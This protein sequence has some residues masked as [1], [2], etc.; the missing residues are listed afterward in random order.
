[1]KR[2][3]T[4]A[5]LCLS[6]VAALLL[7]AAA[8]LLGSERGNQWLLAQIPG[9]HI[10]AGQGRLLDAWQAQRIL[11][12]GA[13]L[14]IEL[15][16]PKLNWS[17]SCLFKGA[18]CIEQLSAQDVH[19]ETGTT[20]AEHETEPV[21]LPEL[22]LPLSLKLKQLSLGRL[23]LQGQELLRN[24][25][26]SAHSTGNQ[27]MVDT[28]T[29]EQDDLRLA[30][31]G[32][33]SLTKGWPVNLNARAQLNY[34]A[35]QTWQVQLHAQGEL[36]HR[37]NLHLSSAGFLNAQA[38]G[39]LA[40][41]NPNLAAELTL[42]SERFAPQAGLPDEQ[43]LRNIAITLSGDLAQGYA[44]QAQAELGKLAQPLPLM[45]SG[46]LFSSGVQGLKLAL[47]RAPQQQLS[48]SGTLD[49]RESFAAQAQLDWQ[50][51][52]W[53]ELLVE[54]PALDWKLKQAHGP[55]SYQDG[56][57]QGQL[58][59]QLAG[60]AGDFELSSPLEGDAHTL[61]IKDLEIKA[62]AGRIQGQIE[63][64]F[65]AQAGWKAELNLSQF[66]PA[67]WLKELPGQVQGR[68]SS[69]GQWSPQL[70]GQLSAQLNGRL[71]QQPLKLQLEAQAAPEQWQ[72]RGVQLAW[73]NNQLEGQFGLQQQKLQGRLKAQFKQLAQL[74]PGLSGQISGT[75]QLAGRLEAPQAQWQL[76]A[77]GLRLQQLASA[78]IQLSG[79]LKGQQL[80]AQLSATQLA[81]G[82][83]DLGALQLNVSGA[84]NQPQ[85]VVDWQAPDWDT[86]LT[87]SGREQA[88]RWQGALSQA[89][90]RTG[91]VN[92]QLLKPAPWNYAENA[93]LT[94]AAHCWQAGQAQLC[95]QRQ[96]L[97]PDTQLAL[98]L[99]DV[100]LNSLKP[101]LPE[102]LSWQATAQGQLSL[103]LST[104]GPRGQ[105]TL[106]A[107]PGSWQVQQDEQ[108]IEL[109][110]QTLELSGQLTPS[111]ARAQFNLGGPQ[112][113][114]LRLEAQTDPRKASKPLS[115]SFQVQGVDI[116]LAR[117]F[118]SALD[119]LKGRLDGQGQLSG[120]LLA[121]HIQGQLALSEG[122]AAGSGLPLDIEQL[123][124]KAQFSG[125]QLTV[126]GR[127]H[128]GEQGRGE[129]SG[130][131]DWRAGL[132]A[133]T[134][135]AS[136]S[137]PITLDPYGE[138]SVSTQ[139]ALQLAEQ[140]LRLSGEVQ[141]P[142]GLIEIRQLPPQAVKV[143][144]D[145]VRSDQPPPA[146]SGPSLTMDVRVLVGQERLRFKGLGL[147]A[148]IRGQLHLGDDLRST[149]E[150]KLNNGRYRAY[151]QRLTVRRARLLFN[152]PISQPYLD[153]EAVR[154]AGT[155]TA[156]IRVSGPSTA[157]VSRVFATPAMSDDQALSYLLTGRPLGGGGDNQALSSAALAM[158]LSGSLPF[159]GELAEKL[160]ISDLQLGADEVSGRLSDR[161]TLSYGL[162]MLDQG[163]L[164]TLRYELTR[165]LYLEAASGIISSLDVV[166]KRDF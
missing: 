19:I 33:L 50:N 85:L 60:P 87:L 134:Q 79:Q 97:W 69:Q 109:P 140:R 24:L 90:I 12:Q 158:G 124:L 48:L 89:H 71:R 95:A 112:L 117:P 166:Y 143:S 23:H 42:H 88:G 62:G 92:W 104:A 15:Q 9:L 141:V 58:R 96:R 81:Q 32:Q 135:F 101:W 125:D 127:F 1:M 111:L 37:L 149:G 160:G 119:T 20:S 53:E 114:N 98:S 52:P 72:L 163:S 150:L 78:Q 147:T 35:Q 145:A 113:G 31:D 29:V 4:Y 86:Q 28:L 11:W 65:D 63:L 51:L 146:P 156:G 118:I 26:L 14:R 108:T 40:P 70:L 16:E 94:L 161:L 74:W 153:V 39:W 102:D 7:G 5:L 115:G 22:T 159:T 116:S 139:L 44:V 132:S 105:F 165:R 18:L 84:L 164:L 66:N 55:L 8:G 77:Q 142:R 41:L 91:A 100:P 129:L 34:L 157:P 6:V 73:G 27:L 59:A 80:K 54:P 82:E 49:W 83:Q 76:Q 121:P 2:A 120:T 56:R 154:K 25:Q 30:L 45:L 155:V 10:E 136:Q 36:A 43:T 133:Q 61:N 106:S 110:Y 107:S 99:H 151:G 21:T 144:E 122:Y 68:I 130:T 67:Y 17:P 103:N 137:L 3:L 93:G 64:A 57:Y 13:D 75:A 131:L 138:V 128:S 123:A 152:G 148:D 47:G 162:G 38:S 126:N 46:Q